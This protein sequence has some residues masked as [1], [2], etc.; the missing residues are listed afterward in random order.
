MQSFS[1]EFD[2]TLKSEIEALFTRLDKDKNGSLNAEEFTQLVRP[3]DKTGSIT[4]DRAYDI[5]RKIDINGDGRIS[6]PEFI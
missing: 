4:V 2:A 5:I 6:K 3:T 1:F